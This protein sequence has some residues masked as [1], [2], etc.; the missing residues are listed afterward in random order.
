LNE[1]KPSK[2]RWDLSRMGKI[3]KNLYK[4]HP[5]V[6]VRSDVSQLILKLLGF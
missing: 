5:K 3:E 6:A 4:E 2:K 1:Y